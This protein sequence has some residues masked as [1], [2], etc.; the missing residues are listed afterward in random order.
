MFPRLSVIIRCR[1]RGSV[2]TTEILA[3]VSYLKTTVN[4]LIE[5]IMDNRQVVVDTGEFIMKLT[6]PLPPDVTSEILNEGYL[7]VQGA[8]DEVTEYIDDLNRIK[9]SAH[10]CLHSFML[11]CSKLIV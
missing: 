6:I 5:K 11:S 2:N 8:R 3:S 9:V 4:D 7:H 1:I 10:R